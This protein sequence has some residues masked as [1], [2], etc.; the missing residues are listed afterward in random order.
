[1]ADSETN[2]SNDRAYFKFVMEEASAP[3]V[4]INLLQPYSRTRALICLADNQ[5]LVNIDSQFKAL[6]SQNSLLKGPSLLISFCE[7]EAPI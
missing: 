2:Q 4:P 3:I 1:M 7:T 5:D 6:S